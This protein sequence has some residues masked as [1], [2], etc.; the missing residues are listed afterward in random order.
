MRQIKLFLTPAVILTAFL[1]VF[2]CGAMPDAVPN[3]GGT[4][5]TRPERAPPCKF[6]RLL[7]CTARALCR[8]R[9]NFAKS[10]AT[11]ESINFTGLQK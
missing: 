3:Y 9:Q 2:V 10:T 5:R 6:A 7:L 1:A 8:S 4:L 11:S